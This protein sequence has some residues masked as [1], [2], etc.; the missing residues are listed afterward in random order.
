MRQ[1]RQQKYAAQALKVMRDKHRATGPVSDWERWVFRAQQGALGLVD[2]FARSDQECGARALM[3]R[4]KCL[5]I[6]LEADKRSVTCFAIEVS[7][8]GGRTFV[9]PLNK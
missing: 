8:D 2:E 1:D 5:R 9:N 7:K 6:W 4:S 3:D